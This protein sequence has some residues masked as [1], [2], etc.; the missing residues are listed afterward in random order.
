VFF[1]PVFDSGTVSTGVARIFSAS[2][3]ATALAHF[4][5]GAD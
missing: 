5:F 3:I 1:E 2:T 4:V